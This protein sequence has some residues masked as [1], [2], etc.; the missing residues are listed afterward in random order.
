MGLKKENDASNLCESSP[1]H[2]LNSELLQ[3][4]SKESESVPLSKE[5]KKLLIYKKLQEKEK[6][7]QSEKEKQEKEKRKHIAAQ[8]LSKSKSLKKRK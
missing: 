2:D 6:I 1:S 8:V 4:K 3:S 7:L 5:E